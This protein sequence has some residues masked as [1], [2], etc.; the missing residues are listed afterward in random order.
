MLN[1]LGLWYLFDATN[2]EFKKIPIKVGLIVGVPNL[3][4]AVYVLANNS[5]AK[6]TIISGLIAIGISIILYVISFLVEKKYEK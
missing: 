5:S 3:I 2:V 6:T 4:Q 1:V